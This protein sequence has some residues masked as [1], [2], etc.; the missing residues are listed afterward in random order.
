M[1]E[2]P[3]WLESTD[4]WLMNTEKLAPVHKPQSPRGRHARTLWEQNPVNHREPMVATFGPHCTILQI[5]CSRNVN[6][7]LGRAGCSAVW[8]GRCLTSNNTVL[9]LSNPEKNV[10]EI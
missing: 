4:K 3:D 5:L 10:N 8:R 6:T 1:S 2:D 7:A 9:D